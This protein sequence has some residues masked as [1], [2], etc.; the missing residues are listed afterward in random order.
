MATLPERLIEAEGAYHDMVIGRGIAR[1]RDANG[2][3]IQYSK[4]DPSRLLAY[5]ADLKAQIGGTGTVCPSG[6][7]RVFF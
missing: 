1:V 7:M 6:P 5:I 3:E 4:A 2:E